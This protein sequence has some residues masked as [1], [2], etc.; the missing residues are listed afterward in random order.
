MTTSNKRIVFAA[1]LM[2]LLLL[3]LGAA[4]KPGK[5]EKLFDGKTLNGW[6]RKA[7]H[8][9]NGGIWTV[10]KGLLVGNQEPD[11]R[12]GLLGTTKLYGDFEI[13]LEFQADEPVDSGLFLRTQPNGV[14]YQVTIDVRPDGSIGSI[15]VP[16]ADFTAQDRGWRPKYRPGTWNKLRAIITGEKQPRLQVWLN[17]RQTV[18]WTD[19][20]ENRLPREGYIGVQVHGGSGSWGD[21]C[22]VRYKNIRVRSL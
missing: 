21:D 20:R 4:G 3:T 19:N 16:G 11:H 5:W 22:R 8:G 6:E 9:G 18:D 2:A 15:Y 12:G 13:E 14:G 1:T 17:G 7:V 10:E